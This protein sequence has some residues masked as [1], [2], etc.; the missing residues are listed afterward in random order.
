M[1]RGVDDGTRFYPALEQGSDEWLRLRE[2]LGCTFSNLGTAFGV[3]YESRAKY[4]RIKTQREK[5]ESMNDVM[6][7]GIVSFSSSSVNLKTVRS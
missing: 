5:A 3:G 2:Q 4:W 6:Q 7:F 1:I